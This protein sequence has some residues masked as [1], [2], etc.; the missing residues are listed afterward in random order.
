MKI[1]VAH[2]K[3]FKNLIN[4]GP[5]VAWKKSKINKRMAYVYSGQVCIWY[6]FN[7]DLNLLGY[8]QVICWED[9]K[10]TLHYYIQ[11]NV[12]EI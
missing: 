12:L 9:Q 7:T 11:D 1:S 2:G 6:V 5:C 8:I 4:V 3:F 10:Q